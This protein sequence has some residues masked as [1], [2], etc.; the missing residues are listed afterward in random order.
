M[1]GGSFNYAYG[2]VIQFSEE[3]KNSI[4]KNI[5]EFPSEVMEKLKQIII[6]TEEAAF[7]MK[8]VE[9]L[10]SGDT[11]DKTFMERIKKYENKV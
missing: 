1:S 9:W 5:D 7:L 6:K 8:E 11:S 4:D 2:H 3:L 10:Y